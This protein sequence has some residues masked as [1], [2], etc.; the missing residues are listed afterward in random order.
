MTM[1]QRVLPRTASLLRHDTGSR[2]TPGATAG[3]IPVRRIR[4][5]RCVRD[6]LGCRRRRLYVSR[7]SFAFARDT[8]LSLGDAELPEGEVHEDEFL[9]KQ[10]VYRGNFFVRI[11]YTVKAT[12]AQR[13]LTIKS[14]GCLDTGFCYPPQTWIETVNCDE[15]RPAASK[16]EFG[17]SAAIGDSEFPPVTKFSSRML[18][19]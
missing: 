11:P 8:A 4:C 5:R 16:L 3:R 10:D 6:R 19:G 15:R 9:G 17:S 13:D 18:C 7:A 12:A 1:I 14:R 2:K